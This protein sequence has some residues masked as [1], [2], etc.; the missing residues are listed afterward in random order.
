MRV[1]LL[2]ISA[3]SFRKQETRRIKVRITYDVNALSSDLKVQLGSTL[4]MRAR[5]A[6]D[7]EAATNLDEVTL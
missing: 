2:I 1:F 5:L 4:K 7:K 3:S 6:G